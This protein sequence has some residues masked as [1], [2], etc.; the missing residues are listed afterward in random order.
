[1]QIV[2]SEIGEQILPDGGHFERSPMY[3]AMILED[4]LDLLNICASRTERELVQL[5]DRLQV[6]TQ[7]MAL[8]PHEPSRRRD[9]PLQR[10]S[11]QVEDSQ[12]SQTSAGQ[13]VPVPHGGGAGPFPRRATT[14]WRRSRGTG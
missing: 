7:W 11:L 14:S 1:L 4:C 13:R 2:D 5:R 8:S 12:R 9:S 10:R 3:H 6:V